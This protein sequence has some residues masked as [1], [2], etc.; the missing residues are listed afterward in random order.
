MLSTFEM[1]TKAVTCHECNYTSFKAS[2]LCKSQGHR[3]KVGGLFS[4]L[5]AVILLNTIC[6]IIRM[7]MLCICLCEILRIL[8]IIFVRFMRLIFKFLQA[9]PLC[10]YVDVKTHSRHVYLSRPY[11][12][13]WI[14]LDVLYGFVTY[15]FVR[16]QFLYKVKVPEGFLF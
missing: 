11:I 1:K 7:Y 8:V 6:L 16:K 2:D 10:N 13:Y 5:C 3:Y 9:Q 15:N 4:S 12:R 14:D